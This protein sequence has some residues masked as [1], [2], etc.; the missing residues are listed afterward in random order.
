MLAA[1]LRREG[2]TG[3]HEMAEL[4]R[5]DRRP[6]AWNFCFNVNGIAPSVE[7]ERL[8]EYARECGG[9]VCNFIM[10]QEADQRRWA[11][12]QFF[13]E[14]DAQRFRQNCD[15]RVVDGRRL[16]VRPLARSLHE[17][18]SEDGRGPVDI[19][20]SKV[21]D[22]VTHLVGFNN[23]SSE[24][25]LIE[26]DLSSQEPPPQ[27]QSLEQDSQ[28]QQQ[29]H[30][31]QQLQQRQQP[32]QPQPAA[33]KV[34]VPS[35]PLPSYTAHVRVQL[36]G[37]CAV[38]VGESGESA[39]VVV[40]GG[41]ASRMALMGQAKK[42]AITNAVKAALASLVVIRLPT[43]K[44]VVRPLETA[45]GAAEPGARHT[46]CGAT[47]DNEVLPRPA[48]GLASLPPQ[49]LRQPSSTHAHVID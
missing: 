41:A 3:Q 2:N 18:Y 25:L 13:C 14:S 23:W 6:G 33:T 20:A 43:G 27:Q 28:L 11:T 1:E 49:Q 21:I 31:P 42:G 29:S 24:V 34:A 37:T 46:C 35:T 16:E 19:P 36:A 22:L 40:G 12:V 32:Q 30:Q 17:S 10:H 44:V 38:G 7:A 39:Q 26:E 45:G 48:L 15:G 9:P 5:L 47:K 4:I 8:S